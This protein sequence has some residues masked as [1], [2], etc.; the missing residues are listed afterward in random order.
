[1]IFFKRR[2]SEAERHFR[3]ALRYRDRRKKDFDFGESIS[4]FK[5][6]MRLE[7][8]N[9]VFHCQLARLYAAAPLLAITRGVNGALNLSKSA[10]LAIAEA[11]EA[12]RLKPNYAEAYMI[13]GEGYMY[14]DEKEKAVQAFEAVLSLRC[15]SRL[16]AHAEIE[17]GQVEGGLNSDPQSEAA[18]RHLEQAL[19]YRNGGRYSLAERQLNKAIKLAPDWAWLYRNLCELG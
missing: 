14:L 4:H 1:V 18:R 15:G 9:A 19:E 5:Q 6:A 11:K 12:L 13:L 17:S 7:P 3:E 16:R 10:S 8:N 2:L